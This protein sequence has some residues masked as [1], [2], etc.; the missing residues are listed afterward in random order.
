MGKFELPKL[1]YNYDA[2]EPYID[3]TTMEIHHTKHHNAYV[4]KLNEAIA[5]TELEKKS[6]E[7]ILKE[8]GVITEP[9]YQEATKNKP[10]DYTPGRGFTLMTPDE[11]FKLQI[12][13]QLS[14]RETYTDY[15]DS[16]KTDVNE[17][18]LLHCGYHASAPL[19]RRFMSGKQEVRQ[20][21]NEN[22]ATKPTFCCHLPQCLLGFVIVLLEIRMNYFRIT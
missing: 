2:L 10:V 13:M 6:L 11:L 9:E 12:G 15:F 8:K 22:P 21:I 19:S 17:F 14:I 7:E 5:G 3:K 20:G 18:R 16:S 4:T 1:P